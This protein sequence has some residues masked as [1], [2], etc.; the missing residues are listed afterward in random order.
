M[1]AIDQV[2]EDIP[3]KTAASSGELQEVGSLLTI[4]QAYTDEAGIPISHNKAVVIG[5][6]LLAFLR[7]VHNGE[8]LPELEESLFDELGKECI[9]ASRRLLENGPLP[10]ER[11]LDDAEV[12]Y[13]AVHFESAKLNDG[14]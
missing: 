1:Y 2:L 7:R 8:Y 12:F 5:I 3:Q 11:K 13:L 14:E 4:M 10:P 6:H 9:E